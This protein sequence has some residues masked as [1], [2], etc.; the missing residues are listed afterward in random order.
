MGN[1]NPPDERV[2]Y[3]AL[4]NVFK[5]P[6]A[7]VRSSAGSSARTNSMGMSQICSRRTT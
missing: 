3:L 1:K 5:G 4:K 2:V 6:N 7:G